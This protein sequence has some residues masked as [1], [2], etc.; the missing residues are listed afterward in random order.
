[1]R[2]TVSNYLPALLQEDND[3]ENGVKRAGMHSFG[4][5]LLIRVLD[6]S[7]DYWM[8]G[9]KQHWHIDLGSKCKLHQ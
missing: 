4:L 6:H 8:R 9:W 3:V 1:M 5:Y 2:Q 7:W